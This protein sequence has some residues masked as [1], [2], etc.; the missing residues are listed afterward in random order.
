MLGGRAGRVQMSNGTTEPEPGTDYRVSSVDNAMTLLA[1]LKDLPSL[2]VKEAAALLGV[3]P[4]TAHRLLTT[5]QGQGFVAQNPETRR[6]GAGPA[7]FEVALA[8]LQRADVRRAARAHLVALSAEVRETVSLTVLEGTSVRFI[9][10]IEGLERV[11]GVARSGATLPAHCTAGG[12]VLLAAL[13]D[14]E[15]Q[16]LYPNEELRP[17]TVHSI[18]GRAELFDELAAVRRRHYATSFEQSTVGL[19]ATSVP[20]NDPQGRPIAAL[21]VSVFAARLDND[22]VT[23]LVEASSARARRVEEELRAPLSELSARV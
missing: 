6:Y 22:T 20:V 2:A 3:A 7:L 14:V 18:T 15:L 1:A 19:S 10:S 5:L 16:R 13:S 8:A 17:L 23:A 12:K 21:V 9:D 11:R 4:S